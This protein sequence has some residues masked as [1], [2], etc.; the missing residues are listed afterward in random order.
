MNIFSRLG[1]YKRSLKF[2]LARKNNA[3]LEKKIKP[4]IYKTILDEINKALYGESKGKILCLSLTGS[5]AFG[6]G[7]DITDY[8]IHG[9]FA[10]KDYWDWVHIGRE[11]LDIN[12]RELDYI[13]SHFPKYFS[14]EFFQNTLGNPIYLDSQFD[15]NGL[16]SLCNA[17]FCYPNTV[18]T[19]RLR[20]D[21]NPRAALHCYRGLMVQIY[22]LKNRKFELNIFKI[23]KQ[24]YNFRMLPIL[25][26]KYLASVNNRGG[27]LNEEEQDIVM[28]DLE[29]LQGDFK[30][31]KE[32]FKNEKADMEKFEKWKERAKRLYWED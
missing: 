18:E 10:K 26:D 17:S 31:L 4:D 7:G 16:S 24:Y 29:R 21:F 11:G 1:D 12:L 19:K 15:Y 5:R 25:R 13:S 9:I 6:W 14:F 27:I 8:D 32:K 22:F 2:F 20:L 30:K 28:K 3:I 23:N